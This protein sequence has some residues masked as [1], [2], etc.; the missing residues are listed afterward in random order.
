MTPQA[1]ILWTL[2]LAAALWWPASRMIWVLSVRRLERKLERKLEAPEIEGQKR[3]AWIL[4]A[5]LCLLF[6]AL[7]NFRLLGPAGGAG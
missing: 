1:Y 3:R 7:F 2:A 6:S 5:V 4:S